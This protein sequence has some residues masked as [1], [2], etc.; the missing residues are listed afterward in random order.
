[1][2]KI[3]TLKK[4]IAVSLFAAMSVSLTGCS[5][6]NTSDIQSTPTS[7]SEPA[8]TSE[9]V[10]SAATA[11]TPAAENSAEASAPAE[12]STAVE[13]TPESTVESTPYTL[14][15]ELTEEMIKESR[16]NEGNKVR[17]AK[18]IKKLQANEEVTVAYIGG[19][20]TQGISAGDDDCYARLTTN[21]LEEKFPGAKINYVNA[22]IGATGSVCGM[23]RADTDIIEKNPDLVFV[24]FSVNDTTENTELNKETYA[25]LLR[26]LWAAPTSPAIVTIAMTQENGTSFQQ[27]HGEIIKMFDLP[28]ISYKNTILKTIQNGYITWDDIS[29]DNIHPNVAGH[30]LL[31]DLIT[32]YLQ[33]VIDDVDNISGD[34]SNFDVDSDIGNKYIGYK[35]ITANNYEPKTPG[36]FIKTEAGSNK[37]GAQ[38]TV[39]KKGGQFTEEDAIEFEF[40]GTEAALMF[41]KLTKYGTKLD[42]FIDGELKTTL[43]G[44]LNISITS[45]TDFEVVATGLAAGK[46]TLK[47]MPQSIEPHA[48]VY[49]SAVA[50]K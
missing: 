1:M 20:I 47:I 31:S 42:I 27:Y 49:I 35:F 46:H 44:A 14:G 19:S 10:S 6:N 38:W 41:G 17:L 11:S 37:F 30:A 18:V 39:M 32:N 33:S 13:S 22:G 15:G 3:S 48:M 2:R 26:K 8:A 40:E 24:E 50:Y 12:S 36:C 5:G 9:P 25:A 7:A 29:N 45:Y 4:V 34:E 21:W 28:M 43:D 16:Y 23:A